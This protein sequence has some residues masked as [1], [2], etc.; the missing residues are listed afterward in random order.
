MSYHWLVCSLDFPEISVKSSLIF[1]D[2][3]KYKQNFRLCSF[4]CEVTMIL[5]RTV[6]VARDLEGHW[7]YNDST[8][9]TSW[10]L[11]VHFRVRQFSSSKVLHWGL[12]VCWSWADAN[13][14]LCRSHATVRSDY[15]TST[16]G[17]T[18][19]SLAVQAW[20]SDCQWH[21]GGARDTDWLSIPLN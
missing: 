20:S 19:S 2:S 4:K 1:E 13:S 9:G 21:H 14:E 6:P 15:Q 16:S 17:L 5:P 7:V 10:S 18:R 8:F 12:N 11:C 3:G